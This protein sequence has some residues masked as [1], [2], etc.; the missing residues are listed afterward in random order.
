MTAAWDAALEAPGWSGPPVWMHGD[1][2]PGNLLVAGGRLRAVI[3]FGGVSVGDPACE[4][5][6]AWSLFSGASR[7]MYR[8]ALS[9]DEAT[10]ARG[11]GWALTSVMAIPYY[12]ETNPG[13]VA[14]ARHTL[15]HVLA[16]HNSAV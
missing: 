12:L 11:R 9:V 5:I 10:W 15:E 13:M 3:D 2:S 16:D 6:P 14:E 1:L 7:D 8:D 4:V